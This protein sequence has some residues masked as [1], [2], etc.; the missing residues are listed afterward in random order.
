M[1]RRDFLRLASYA[2]VSL[3]TPLGLGR[4]FASDHNL[5]SE[6]YSGLFLVTIHA[7]GGWDPTSFC[8]PKGRENEATDS[9]DT[10]NKS[11]Q[12]GEPATQDLVI[13]KRTATPFR[14]SAQDLP[15]VRRPSRALS[16]E[17]VRVADRGTIPTL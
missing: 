15:T 14:Q 11:H 10:S 3:V 1:D 8:D 5:S 13:P 17:Q 4:A 7:S 6:P 2:G 12:D 16:V 9:T